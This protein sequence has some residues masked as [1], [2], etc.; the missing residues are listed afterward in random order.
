LL[1]MLVSLNCPIF[2]AHLLF[3]MD[4]YKINSFF[5]IL[6]NHLF[7]NYRLVI[8]QYLIILVIRFQFLLTMS[9]HLLNLFNLFFHRL[10]KFDFKYPIYFI[11]NHIQVFKFFLLFRFI[12]IKFF[13]PNQALFMLSFQSFVI[14]IFQVILIILPSA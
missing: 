4:C 14:L 9:R 2:L 6:H 8:F 1:E 10:L 13:R 3:L 5:K 11:K 7:L 12:I